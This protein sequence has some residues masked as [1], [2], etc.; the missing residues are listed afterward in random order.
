MLVAATLN[1][2]DADRRCWR[3][4]L[5]SRARQS[6]PGLARDSRA[7]IFPSVTP[8]H[9]ENSETAEDRRDCRGL[10]NWCDRAVV[11]TNADFINGTHAAIA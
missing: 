7:G 9:Q 8:S 6:V 1:G 4:Q 10:G 5:A 2:G 11:R 3:L